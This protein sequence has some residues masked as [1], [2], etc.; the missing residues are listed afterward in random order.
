MKIECANPGCSNTAHSLKLKLGM[1]AG[2]GEWDGQWFCSRKCYLDVK[3]DHFIAAKQDSLRK[4]V[5]RV[6]LGLLLVKNDLIDQ[7]TLSS[8]LDQQGHSSKK[9]GEMLVDSEKITGRELKTML[10]MQ[11]GVA[12]VKLDPHLTVKLKDELPF[13]LIEEF[14]FV[15]FKYDAVE[16]TLSIGIYDLELLSCL[17]E[18]FADLYPGFLVKFYLDDKENIL[19]IL[20][21]NYPGEKE[22]FT[23]PTVPEPPAGE[24]ITPTPVEKLVYKVVGFL[25]ECGAE[26]VK[27]DHQEESVWITGRLDDLGIDIKI[28]HQGEWDWI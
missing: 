1:A 24:E 12:A 5:R 2:G 28:S 19:T 25:N 3:A 13:K 16:K 18:M 11:A 10:S 21:N 4:T 27:I 20:E 17:E 22:T 6:K 14:H 9:L 7:E 15:L 26:V 23:G 8:A